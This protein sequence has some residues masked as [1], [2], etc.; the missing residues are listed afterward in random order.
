MV[1][2][3]SDRGY[4]VISVGHLAGVTHGYARTSTSRRGELRVEHSIR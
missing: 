2:R 1:D 4:Y 3:Q